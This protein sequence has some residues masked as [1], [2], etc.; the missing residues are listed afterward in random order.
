M[1]IRAT[2]SDKHLKAK[3]KVDAIA[4]ML[5]DRELGVDELIRVAGDSNNK[6]KGTCIEALEFATRAEPEV[7]SAACLDFVVESLL[8]EAPRVKWESA[9]VVANIAQR[10]PERL[11]DAVTNLVANS[12]HPG[13]VVRWSAAR[14][15]GEIVKLRT[16]H[17]RTLIPVIEAV[18]KRNDEDKAI[19]KIYQ[20]AVKKAKP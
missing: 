10:Y 17:N 13:T 9:K 3:D 20:S 4:K 19:I 18:L 6:E 15:L 11:C 12:E 8:D 5:L 7:A 14:A 2:L 16:R 1:D